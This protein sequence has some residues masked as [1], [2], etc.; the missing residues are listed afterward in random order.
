MN[1]YPL[2]ALNHFT[3]PSAMLCQS[4]RPRQGAQI[5]TT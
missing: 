3:L 4:S 1:P 5:K 2:A